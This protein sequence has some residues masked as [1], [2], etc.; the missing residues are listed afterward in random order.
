ME[1]HSGGYGPGLKGENIPLLTLSR[2]EPITSPTCQG[3]WEVWT[4]CFPG[5]RGNTFSRVRHV[6]SITCDLDL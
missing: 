1:E 3:G 4:D 2:L 5:R 6:A